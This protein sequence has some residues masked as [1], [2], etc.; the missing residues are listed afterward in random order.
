MRIILSRKGFD[1]GN[2][3]I[4]SPI[5]PDGTLLSMPIPSEDGNV[6]YHDIIY[7]G[8]TYYDIIQ[9]LSPA[10]AQRIENS[11][12]HVDPDLECHYPNMAG[13]K[14]AFGQCGMSQCHLK[15]NDVG[16]GDIFLFYGWFRQTEY[17]ASGKLR[18][19]KS[20]ADE[21]PDRHIIYGYMEIGDVITE[22][23]VI[24]R[25]YPWHPHAG[26]T[27][28]DNVLYV[29]K[30]RFSLDEQKKGY[31]LLKNTSIRQ[32][33]KSGH[34]RS[35]WALPDC[36]RDAEITFHEGN[37]YG[38]VKGADYFRSARIGQEFII[39]EEVSGELKHWLLAV[40]R[41]IED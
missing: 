40:I 38:W 17:D 24:D 28:P 2:G 13:W 18:F 29:P 15:N 7:Q 23:A 9:Q 30:D 22:Q 41:Y 11:K 6:T 12:C 16:V 35:E 20:G 1:S 19:V 4:P 31:G 33:T 21:T 34:K 37:S 26:R 39:K 32:L 3:G 14:P 27:M 5:M 8:K 36:L 25:E 10:V